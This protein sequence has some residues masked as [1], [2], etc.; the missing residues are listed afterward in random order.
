MLRSIQTVL[1]SCFILCGVAT[2]GPITTFDFSNDESGN[3]IVNGQPIDTEFSS[4]FAVSGSGINNIDIADLGT[5]P[6][7]PTSITLIDI[8]DNAG[9]NV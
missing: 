8:D 4:T 9:V 6:T 5:T 7:Q 3:P 2:A 1:L